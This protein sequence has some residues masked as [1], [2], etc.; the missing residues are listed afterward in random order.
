MLTL[1]ALS[2]LLMQQAPAPVAPDAR[3]RVMFVGSESSAGLDRDGD[4]YI[5]REEFLGPLNDH[6]TSMDKDGD[7]RLSAEELRAGGGAMAGDGRNIIMMRPS[8]DSDVAGVRRFELRREGVGSGAHAGRGEGRTMVFVGGGTS[9]G[10]EREIIVHGGPGGRIVALADP[11][12]EG[13]SGERVRIRRLGGPGG[14]S[15]LDTDNDG[16]ISE[17][18]FLAPM[19]EAFARMDADG[20]GFIAAGE[21]GAEVFVHRIETRTAG[22]D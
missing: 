22:Q 13:G 18:E 11:D 14:W 6:F 17:A 3:T 7:G 1:I 5:S 19:R 16:R 21:R 8:G 15:D 20:S 4:G 9:A 10:G 2:S 12:G